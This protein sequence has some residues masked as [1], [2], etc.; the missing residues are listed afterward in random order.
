MPGV[1]RGR[2]E[3]AS[4][5]LRN[6]PSVSCMPRCLTAMPQFR[7][8]SAWRA[9]SMPRW[10][11]PP[12]VP[13]YLVGG[14]IRDLLRGDAG[15]T[16]VDLAVDGD[17]APVARRL[18]RRLGGAARVTV[19][20]AFGTSTVRWEDMRVD[21]ARTRS[22]SYARPGLAARGRA[23]RHRGRPASPRLHRERDGASA[24]ER[25]QPARPGRRPRRPRAPR[26]PRA[27]PR[28]VS[29]RPDPGLPGRA[30]RRPARLRARSRDRRACA[31]GA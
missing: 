29:R 25:R 26:D 15:I 12:A 13:L 5:R 3:R 16:D 17:A 24:R 20:T 31:R 7:F 4:E 23:G 11:R 2:G 14:A 30:L 27:P 22:E 9:R 18:A 28:V 8:P 10:M 6:G 1:R 21:I 19:H